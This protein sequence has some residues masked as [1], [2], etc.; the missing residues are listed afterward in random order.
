HYGTVHA[1]A[2]HIVGRGEQTPEQGWDAER[3]KKITADKEAVN[4]LRLAADRQGR[5]RAPVR[6]CESAIEQA[7]L[8]N[9]IKGRGAVGCPIPEPLA[10]GKNNE[11][12]G[13][14]DG[15]G[16]QEQSVDE[17]KNRDIGSDAECERQDGHGGQQRSASQHAHGDSDIL[18]KPLEPV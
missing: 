1:T 9:L 16:A 13:L 6:K 3:V 12:L 7:A 8:P 5:L 15:Q 4:S 18:A 11:S 2:G 10:C 14:L 17:R